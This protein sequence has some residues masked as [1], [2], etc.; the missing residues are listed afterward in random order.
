MYISCSILLF[1]Y[2]VYLRTKT[3]NFITI[4]IIILFFFFSSLNTSTSIHLRN[5]RHFI[6]YTQE[7]QNNFLKDKAVNCRLWVFLLLVFF[8]CSLFLVF[9]VDMCVCVCIVGS[10]THHYHNQLSLLNH[11]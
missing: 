7:T 6:S 2:C 10:N 11:V 4:I 1:C 5:N 8:S 9:I 3:N